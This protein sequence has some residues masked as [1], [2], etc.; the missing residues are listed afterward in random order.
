MDI[1]TLDMDIRERDR[2]STYKVLK[3]KIIKFKV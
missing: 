2:L 1:Q 3:A